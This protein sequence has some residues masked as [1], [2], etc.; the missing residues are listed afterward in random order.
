MMSP[1]LNDDGIFA[2]TLDGYQNGAHTGK[3]TCSSG[4]IKIL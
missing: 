1:C 4:S 3:T 2:I